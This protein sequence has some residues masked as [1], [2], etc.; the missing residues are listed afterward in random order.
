MRFLAWA[1]NPHSDGGRIPGSLVSFAPRNAAIITA[2]PWNHR[3][4]LAREIVEVEWLG[5]HFHAGLQKAV[6]DR[7]AL[8]VAGDE[9]NLEAGPGFPR[10]IG[11]LAAVH[12]AE[13]GARGPQGGPPPHRPRAPPPPR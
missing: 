12:S 10:L 8:G 6:G 2:L 1:R 9:K 11:E 4:N 3:A 7:G 5:D 13:G